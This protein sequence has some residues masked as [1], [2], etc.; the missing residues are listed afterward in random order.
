MG[1]GK[2]NMTP[3]KDS[4]KGVFARFTN[5][6]KTTAA[7]ASAAKSDHETFADSV[8]EAHTTVGK[9]ISGKQADLKNE[10]GREEYNQQALAK[11]QAMNWHL[12]SI[13]DLCGDYA[14]S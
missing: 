11:L 8:A 6:K 10:K 4:N 7:G 13:M 14:N 12:E 9:L 2:Q 3:S 5:R 1:D